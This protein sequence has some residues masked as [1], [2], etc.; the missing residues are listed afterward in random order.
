M[1]VDFDFLFFKSYESNFK[2]FGAGRVLTVFNLLLI[3]YFY[4]IRKHQSFYIIT[5]LIK[6]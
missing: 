2:Y 6:T 3:N 5:P 4:S 1:T